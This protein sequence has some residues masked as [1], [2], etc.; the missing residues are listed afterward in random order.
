MNASSVKDAP[1][2]FAIRNG[3]SRFRI[4]MGDQPLCRGG[5]W[6]QQECEQFPL[7]H[8]FLC[9]SE[10]VT[11]YRILFPPHVFSPRNIPSHTDWTLR[12][13]D[14]LFVETVEV[15]TRL[16]FIFCNLK[17]PFCASPADEMCLPIRT[18][19]LVRWVGAPA[20]FLQ[21]R[22]RD[23]L[24]V[25][26]HVWVYVCGLTVFHGNGGILLQLRHLSVRAPPLFFPPAR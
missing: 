10:T 26:V 6:M 13:P 21:Q 11:F 1:L 9:C 19:A 3:A 7:L 17:T 14:S 25:H 4:L 18:R 8:S 2:P 24:H 16:N 22:C 15:S 12:Q 5:G 20:I 23:C